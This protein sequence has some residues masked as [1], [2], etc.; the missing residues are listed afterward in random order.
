MALALDSFVSVT[1]PIPH[2]VLSSLGLGGTGHG[3]KNVA[4]VSGETAVTKS[5]L[6]IS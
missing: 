4:G 1:A 3:K 5:E 6:S 2:W